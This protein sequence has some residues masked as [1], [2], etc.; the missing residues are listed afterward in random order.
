M[1]RVCLALSLAACVVPRQEAPRSA[2]AV[3]AA[4]A[5]AVTAHELANQ[6]PEET[7]YGWQLEIAGERAKYLA[8]TAQE[9]CGQRHVEI[10]TSSLVAT[11]VVGRTRPELTDG[12]RG[13]EVD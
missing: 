10:A 13:D 5:G 11:K 8:C 4:V 7:V 6:R 3:D 1:V 9:A 2:S 12:T